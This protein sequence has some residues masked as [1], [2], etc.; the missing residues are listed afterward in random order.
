MGKQYVCVSDVV[1]LKPMEWV[2][3]LLGWTLCYDSKNLLG[4]IDYI[5]YHLAQQALEANNK[6]T[7]EGIASFWGPILDNYVKF[8]EYNLKKVKYLLELPK[9]K[10][11]LTL[12]KADLGEEGSFDDAIQG[13]TDVFHVTTP[14]DFES[15]DPELMALVSIAE[16]SYKPT[17]NGVLSIIKACA[18]ARTVRR[19]VFTSSAGTIDIAEQQKPCYDKS[20]S[21]DLKFIHDKTM[22]GLMYFVSKT[23]AEQASWKF[24]KEK[25]VDFVSI[26]NRKPS[27]EIVETNGVNLSRETTLRYRRNCLNCDGGISLVRTSAI[28]SADGR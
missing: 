2:I 4:R 9:A 21:S 26:N 11:R 20:C 6:V 12:W 10:T 5:L 24:A 17:I 27:L 14:M 3:D 19:L 18:N 28:C 1:T 25:N 7:V 23:M 8:T 22:T 13:C 16:S 15:K